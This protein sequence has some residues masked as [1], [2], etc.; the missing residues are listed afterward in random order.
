MLTPRHFD[1]PWVGK[2]NTRAE[3]VEFARFRHKTPGASGTL[4]CGRK[5]VRLLRFVDKKYTYVHAGLFPD[6]LTGRLPL[7]ATLE[8][9]VGWL[10]WL[11]RPGRLNRHLPTAYFHAGRRGCWVGSEVSKKIMSPLIGSPFA[12]KLCPPI[13]TTLYPDA[14]MLARAAHLAKSVRHSEMLGYK[15]IHEMSMASSCYRWSK[16]SGEHI[17]GLRL[18]E[19]VNEPA[20]DV[21]AGCACGR[22]N[23]L[24]LTLSSASSSSASC[25]RPYSCCVKSSI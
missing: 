4:C 5:S 7:Q 1:R 21:P 3:R 24:S 12:S 18:F 10:A 17:R 6:H 2:T 14:G 22:G 13:G 15:C 25:T 19:R 16:V 23:V 11:M 20:V 9:A 8:P